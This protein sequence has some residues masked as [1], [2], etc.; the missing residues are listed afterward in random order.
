[1]KWLFPASTEKSYEGFDSAGVELFKDDDMLKCLAR[2]VCQNS[3][4]AHKDN[5]EPVEIEFELHKVKTSDFPGMSAL[6]SIIEKCSQFCDEIEADSVMRNRIDECIKCIN[7]PYI[8]VLRISDYNTKGLVGAFDNSAVRT[9]WTGLIKS[10]ALSVKNSTDAAGSKGLGKNAPFANTSIQTVFYRT[11]A[12]DGVKAAQGVARLMSFNDESYGDGVSLRRSVGWFGEDEYQA[13]QDMP[14]LDKLSERKHHGTDLFIPGIKLDDD[15]KWTSR[16]IAEIL[17][18]FLMSIHDG[19]LSIRIGNNVIDKGSLYTSIAK[20][21]SKDAKMFKKVLLANEDEV[22]EENLEFEDMGYAHLRVLY[23]QDLNKK[24]L[25]VRNSGMKIAEIPRLSKNISFSGIL[26]LKGKELN[27]FFREMETPQHDKWIPRNHSKDPIRAKLEKEKLENWVRGFIEKKQLESIGDEVDVNTYDFFNADTDDGENGRKGDT[28]SDLVDE[29][30]RA[31]F[32]EKKVRRNSYKSAGKKGNTLEKGFVD[33][34]GDS[35]G[36][37]HR[38]GRKATK[39]IGRSAIVNP[40]GPDNVRTA[41]KNVGYTA[42]IIKNNLFM[43]TSEDIKDAL[44][45]IVTKGENGKS[46][47]LKV[48]SVKSSLANV[49]CHNGKIYI[50]EL[51]AGEKVSIEFDSGIEDNFA[52]GVVVYGNKE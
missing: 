39:K 42:R 2:E 51:K 43:T 44:I 6:R 23:K 46:L 9:P 13:V 31:Y 47:A 45:E 41:K 3:L 48:S 20:Y 32:S 14:Q 26:E 52:L 34:E 18:N 7:E 49:S 21:G 27:A 25:V 15:G 30:I 38:S 12:I 16:M 8:K 24:I 37:R 11:Y 50:D 36:Y 4:D 29:K 33:E 22:E 5:D 19:K 28:N 40:L 35:V 17:D 10:S 1:M